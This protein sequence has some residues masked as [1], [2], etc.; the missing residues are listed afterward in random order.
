MFIRSLALLAALM[1]ATSLAHAGDKPQTLN[2]VRDCPVTGMHRACLPIEFLFRDDESGRLHVRSV[3]HDEYPYQQQWN[4]YIVVRGSLIDGSA[5]GVFHLK[6]DLELDDADV[7]PWNTLGD[8]AFLGRSL[9]GRPVVLTD[10]GPLEIET[11]AVDFRSDGD[12]YVADRSTGKLA[13]KRVA[14]SDMPFVA[15]KSGMIGIWDV[16]RRICIEA[17]TTRSRGLTIVTSACKAAGIDA[18]AVHITGHYVDGVALSDDDA[19][20]HIGDDAHGFE[21][22][23]IPGTNLTLIWAEWRDCC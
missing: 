9:K 13:S 10:R 1:A 20:R 8:F 16:K 19:L 15:T 22:Y 18:K 12:L 7:M 21:L 23:D 2:A 5:R 11:A 6:L 4:D 3:R 17:P 14:A